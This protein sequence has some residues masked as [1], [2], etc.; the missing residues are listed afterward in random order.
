WLAEMANWQV[1]AARNNIGRILTAR[2]GHEDIGAGF[3]E[4]HITQPGLSSSTE[5]NPKG[6][7]HTFLRDIQDNLISLPVGCPLYS[8]VHHI[9][10]TE[11]FSILRTIKT[12]PQP[13]PSCPYFNSLRL[14]RSSK[15]HTF[16]AVSSS[17]EHLHE[18]SKAFWFFYDTLNIATVFPM[19]GSSCIHSS[20][21]V[22]RMAA[23][24]KPTFHSFPSVRERTGAEKTVLWMRAYACLCKSI[25]SEQRCKRKNH[26][27]SMSM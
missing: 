27:V 9:I 18:R 19:V 26:A 3:L 5:H 15:A 16:V 10:E 1:N 23:S 2:R 8:P 14:D 7:I 6:H 21:I 24:Q 17:V 22:L 13:C 20:L 11:G 12:H 4:A 25:C